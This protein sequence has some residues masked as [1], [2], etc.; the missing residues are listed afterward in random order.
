VTLAETP[1]WRGLASGM[2]G[3]RSSSDELSA[4]KFGYPSMTRLP[5]GDVLALF[6]CLEECI[7]NIRWVRLAM[8]PRVTA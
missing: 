4:L 1:V 2:K 8:E 6:W 7:H 5:G 3:E